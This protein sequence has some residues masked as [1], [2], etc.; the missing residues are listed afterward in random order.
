VTWL[1][2]ILIEGVP[3]EQVTSYKYLGIQLDKELQWSHQVE[4]VSSKI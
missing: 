1:S 2:P 4:Y 3:I